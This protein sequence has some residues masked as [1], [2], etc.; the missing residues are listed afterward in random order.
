MN[1]VALPDIHGGPARLVVP[2]WDGA[3]WVKWVIRFTAAAERNN[4]FFMNPGY[5]YPLHALVPGSVA[6]PADLEVIEAMRVKSAIAYPSDED[7]I[8]SAPLTIRGCL[9]W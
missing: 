1:G 2:G 6:D 4:Q 9:G 8:K 5:R 7:H 3:S